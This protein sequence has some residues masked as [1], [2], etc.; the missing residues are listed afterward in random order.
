MKSP[1]VTR[2]G[3]EKVI[4][5]QSFVDVDSQNIVRAVLAALLRDVDM[6][7]SADI[8]SPNIAWESMAAHVRHTLVLDSVGV[9]LELQVAS[10]QEAA[11]PV[12]V[13]TH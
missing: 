2:V 6:A 10:V 13:V 7:V 12:S 1:A 8:N 3:V 4:N 11:I 9:R 5:D